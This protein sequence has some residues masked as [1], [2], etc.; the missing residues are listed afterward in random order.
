MQICSGESLQEGKKKFPL[1]IY[2]RESLTPNGPIDSFQFTKNEPIKLLLCF[3]VIA[4]KKRFPFKK[5]ERDCWLVCVLEDETQK[6]K[7]SAGVEVNVV[8]VSRWPQSIRPPAVQLERPGGLGGI[9]RGKNDSKEWDSTS[10]RWPNKMA[11]LAQ[12]QHDLNPAS[13]T[14]SPLAGTFNTLNLR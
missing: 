1:P 7:A 10:K 3:K 11:P 13:H 8:H 2:Y 14:P 4:V 5:L 6:C 12:G 9:V